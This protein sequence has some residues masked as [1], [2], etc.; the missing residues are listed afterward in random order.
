V[1][2]RARSGVLISRRERDFSLERTR[3]WRSREL[4]GSRNLRGMNTARDKK[5]NEQGTVKG[6]DGDKGGGG[7]KKG[8]RDIIEEKGIKR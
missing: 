2:P 5:G 7:A 8:Y 4:R 3:L 6:A 1:Q